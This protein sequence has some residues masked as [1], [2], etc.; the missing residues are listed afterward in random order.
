LFETSLFKP[1][2]KNEIIAHQWDT[3]KMAAEAAERDEIDGL[4]P[5]EDATWSSDAEAWRKLNYAE[6]RVGQHLDAPALNVEYL[7]LLDIAKTR[8]SPWRSTYEAEKDLFQNSAPD[9]PTFKKQRA[10]YQS[11]LQALQADFIETRFRRRLRRE[12]AG[13]LLVFGII[14]LLIALAPICFNLGLGPESFNLLIAAC[15]GMLGAY[16][17]RMLSFQT[18]LASI[19]FDDVMNLYV[20]RMLAIR[21][22]FGI[23]GAIVF[24]Y[25]LYAGF[26]GGGVFPEPKSLEAIAKEHDAVTKLPAGDFAKLLIWFF[27]SGFSERLVPDALERTEAQSKP[28]AAGSEAQ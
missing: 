10:L 14:V 25:I 17:S 18:K 5:K 15:F 12:T 22:L 16:F 21:L 13:R 1:S 19:G 11:L 26:L 9:A 3:L 24:Y 28:K 23:I 27:L 6:Q 4:F 2:Y 20:W 8:N 7:T